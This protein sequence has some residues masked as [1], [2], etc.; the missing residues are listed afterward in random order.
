MAQE[1]MSST[2][3]LEWN[4]YLDREPNHFNALHFYLAQIAREVRMAA[5][6]NKKAYS[7][8]DFLLE[9]GGGKNVPHSGNTKAAVLGWLGLSE[10]G[11][12]DN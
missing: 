7:L 4:A 11:A 3:F 1:S 9:F 6:G 8:K 5:F 10:E 2:E 12:K